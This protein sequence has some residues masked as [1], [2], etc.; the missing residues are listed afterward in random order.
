MIRT[1]RIPTL[2]LA[3]IAALGILV[4]LL[5]P[6]IA[7]ADVSVVVNGQTVQFDQP[8][9]VQGGRVFVPL[10]GVFERLGASVVYDNGVINA[11]G[12]GHQV[13]VRIGSHKL[14]STASRKPSTRPRSSSVPALSYRSDSSPK[15]LAPVCN[16]MTPRRW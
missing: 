11:T 6:Q 4:L 12:A 5:V 16:G 14:S 3:V 7:R 13:Q 2:V 9:V 1:E 10:R 8:P 15:R